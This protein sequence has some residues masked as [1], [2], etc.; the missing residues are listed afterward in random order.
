MIDV[1]DKV[2]PPHEQ[3]MCFATPHTTLEPREAADTQTPSHAEAG[4]DAWMIEELVSDFFTSPSEPA[5]T[6]QEWLLRMCAQLMARESNV[7]SVL[8][9][10]AR[11]N[12]SESNRGRG[13]TDRGRG[14]GR[15]RGQAQAQAQAQAQVRDTTNCNNLDHTFVEGVSKDE[16]HSSSDTA[17]KTTYLCL[18]AYTKQ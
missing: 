7:V 6:H 4:L 13:R 3:D 12:T 9:Q 5:S 2:Q 10:N 18:G 11:R 15:G 14:R 16:S 1:H 8:E 17:C